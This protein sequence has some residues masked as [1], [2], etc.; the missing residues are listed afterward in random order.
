MN[1]QFRQ[2]GAMTPQGHQQFNF[3]PGKKD[4]VIESAHVKHNYNTNL[5]AQ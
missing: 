1:L 3:L 4:V 5:L 2:M